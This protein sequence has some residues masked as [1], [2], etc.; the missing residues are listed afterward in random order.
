MKYPIRFALA[1]LVAGLCA[2]GPAAASQQISTKS[3]CAACHAPD[4][5]LIGPSY[6]D[7]ALKYKGRADAPALLADKVRKGGQGVWGPVPMLP[8]DRKTISDADLK[9]VVAWILATPAK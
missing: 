3:G 4:R 7:I 6:K 1:A 8:L 9:A 2:A 5:K